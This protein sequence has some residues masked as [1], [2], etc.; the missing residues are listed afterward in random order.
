MFVTL[1][2]EWA[3]D[4]GLVALILVAN[5]APLLAK[6]LLGR[7][8]SWPIDGHRVLADGRPLFGPSKTWRGVALM[9][10]ITPLAALLAG[11][12]WRLGLGVAVAALL[13]DLLSSFLKRRLGLTPSSQSLG[14][15]EIPEALFPALVGKAMLGLNWI[16][17]AVV[18]LGFVIA[19]R[20]LTR[21]VRPRLD[22]H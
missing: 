14:L 8:G 10:L 17:V 7:V 22:Q 9:L 4:L 1:L 16:D 18:V 5:G 21:V 3:A 11:W 6:L 19:H 13:G 15:D 2:P 20:V 12:S